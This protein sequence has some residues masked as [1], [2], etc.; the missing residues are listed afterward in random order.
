VEPHG[1]QGGRVLAAR[2]ATGLVQ[3]I[4]LYLLYRIAPAGHSNDLASRFFGAALLAAL[5][6]PPILVLGIGALRPRP[7][8]LWTLSSTALV[9][10]LGYYARARRPSGASLSIE[11]W[12]FSL[13]SDHFTL[14]LTL[15]PAGF[16][17]T[18][19]VTDGAAERR[20]LPSYER[21]FE[22]TCAY[23]VQVPAALGF[24]LVVQSILEL[25]ASLFSLIGVDGPRTLVNETW[26]WL[27][28]VT[29]S[30]A[31]AIHA[32][33]SS[34]ALLAGARTLALNLF[35]WLLPLFA[36]IVGAFLIR[37]VFAS[38]A[39]LRDLEYPTGVLLLTA[40]LLVLLINCH[41]QDGAPGRFTH[42][43]RRIALSLA[44]AE[45]TPLVALAAWLLGAR[46]VAYG[47][48]VNRI[49]V[50]AT[51]LISA[52]CAGGYAAA[53]LRSRRR[54]D[55]IKTTNV[56]A[57]YLGIVVVLALS[58]PAA[59]PARL[60]VASQIARL[61]SGAVGAS[62]FDYDALRYQ[63]ERWGEEAL[64]DLASTY[65]GPDAAVVRKLAAPAEKPAY[66]GGGTR[67]TV[68]ARDARTTATA[69]DAAAHLTLYP[70][71]TALPAGLKAVLFPSVNPPLSCLRPGKGRCFARF[72][73]AASDPKPMLA[74]YDESI[75]AIAFFA[76][77][78]G[79]N[80]HFAGSTRDVFA[81]CG[82]ALRAA[83]KRGTLQ[84][85]PHAL[86]DVVVG[87]RLATAFTGP[88]ETD[89]YSADGAGPCVP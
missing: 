78:P 60:M 85:A 21:L 49:F 84:L 86:P 4:V 82:D 48:T 55:G 51:A 40:L 68:A 15:V 59:D 27:P 13:I 57:A 1:P 62:K 54:P 69:G 36:L 63:G 16:A 38:L 53:L 35:S 34:P 81:G 76:Q 19:L 72:I 30:A 75:G 39:P 11:S 50:L 89:W 31:A 33:D 6:I 8:A 20:W 71:G 65:A 61:Q 46:V 14:L 26:F 77:I 18:V 44:V 67:T 42:T 10:L 87:R 3:G 70:P 22:R 2:L 56:A 29:T 5:F 73:S 83:L 28:V 12:P 37:I 25:G 64:R 7:L 9:A 66:G 80:W 79:G 43:I 47:W 24:A 74:V 23:A 88:T 58:S 17:A 45:L 52:C 41:Y 32:T